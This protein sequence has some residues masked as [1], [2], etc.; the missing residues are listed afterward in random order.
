MSNK[1]LLVHLTPSRMATAVLGSSLSGHTLGAVQ[2]CALT[3]DSAFPVGPWDRVY[4][5]LA[6]E[7]ALYRILELPFSDR[8]R[9]SQAI[10]PALEE[11]VPL[12]LE[13]GRVAF[14]F[15]GPGA[16][17]KV[18]AAIARETD[19]EA[20]HERVSALGAA[21][22]RV[23][24]AAPT[25]L[26]AYRRSAG[27]STNYAVVDA[28]ADGAV[29]AGFHGQDLLGLR[30]VGS[31][32]D[33]QLLRSVHRALRALPTTPA[34]LILGG[35]RAD[36]LETELA[37]SFPDLSI[38]R[39]SDAP[40]LGIG[41]GET[42]SETWSNLAALA[43]L[44]MIA[45]GEAEMPVL[46][47]SA[48]TGGSLGEVAGEFRPLLPWAAAFAAALALG[49]GVQTW[50][51]WSAKAELDGKAEAV[52]QKVMGDP[53]GGIGRRLRMEM[54]LSE[55]TGRRI[56][57]NSG[58]SVLAAL[59]ALSDAVPDDLDVELDD[60]RQAGESIRIRG[61][62]ESFETVSRVE[63]AIRASNHFADVEVRDAHATA[64]GDGI[65]FQILLRSG[66]VTS[67]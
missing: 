52:Y 15:A 32:S 19:L 39:L 64:A 33:Q 65:E 58:T 14:D 6:A 37:A 49:W 51:L 53:S 30:I 10:G 9:L 46:D 23:L 31:T 59:A 1:T 47:F 63:E 60:F 38:T 16:G 67:R 56:D 2:E 25:V 42:Q 45:A 36:V 24:W 55:M 29:V 22:T 41:E 21:P 3:D 66:G 17:G 20:L 18:L 35:A 34:K 40:P 4:V 43:G 48:G 44:A 26:Q 5:T 8:A 27:A 7:S 61:R 28:S 11:H 13:E 62:S 54:R 57:D 50:R 12:S